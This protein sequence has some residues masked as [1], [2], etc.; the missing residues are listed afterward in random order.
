MSV[1][2]QEAE[3]EDEDEIGPADEADDCTAEEEDEEDEVGMTRETTG[4][5]RMV[6]AFG[7]VAV[8]TAAAA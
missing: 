5:E 1:R 6:T 3:V 8:V 4:V 2:R 7:T